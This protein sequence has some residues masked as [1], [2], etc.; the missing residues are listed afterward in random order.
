MESTRGH[1]ME[2]K[3]K[4]WI[5]FSLPRFSHLKTWNFPFGWSETATG[6]FSSLLLVSTKNR[7]LWEGPTPEVRD[8][9][10]SCHFIHAHSQVWQILLAENT[11]RLLCACS[12]N[13]TVSEVAILCADQ[14]ERGLW[15]REYFGLGPG[16]SQA[17][18]A[19]HSNHQNL[20]LLRSVMI[21]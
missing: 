7:D 12:E 15:L 11:K 10:T 19:L 8:S 13:W 14:K 21:G 16:T 17:K 20:P 6:S 3:K 4:T 1:D 2:I 5:S 9:R 18:C